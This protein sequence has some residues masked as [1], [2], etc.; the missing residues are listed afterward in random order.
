QRLRRRSRSARSGE[1]LHHE[2]SAA[3]RYVR[4]D[5]RASV[6]LGDD[7]EIDGE[8]QM[9]GGAFLQSEILRLDEHAVGAQVARP[10]K[11][12]GAA[13]CRHV[14]GGSCAVAGMQASLHTQIPEI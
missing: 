14:H 4:D 7:A 5:R 6:N 3:L 1:A 13:G 8:S 9:D 10:A 12:A 11:L 2:P